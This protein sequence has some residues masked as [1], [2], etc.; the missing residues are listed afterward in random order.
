MRSRAEHGSGRRLIHECPRDTGGRVQLRRPQRRPVGDARWIRPRERRRRFENRQRRGSRHSVV[1]RR[2][3]VVCVDRIDARM[4][5]RRRRT[6][7]DDSDRREPLIVDAGDIDGDAVRQSVVGLGDVAE[8]AHDRRGLVDDQRSRRGDRFVI[9]AAAVA[10]L[11]RI[12]A[13]VHR[14]RCP[15][16]VQDGERS[17][18]GAADAVHGDHCRTRLARVEERRAR[19]L[20]GRH[21]LVHHD[22]RGHR[23]RRPVLGVGR[24]QRDRQRMR[25]RV[26]DRSRRRGVDDR[27]REIGRR[28][29][30]RAAE[31]RSVRDGGGLGPVQRRRAA[32]QR[33][34][35]LS[36]R[37]AEPVVA[38]ECR[39]NRVG[40]VADDL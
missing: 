38:V 7:V 21:R 15:A 3:I 14:Q 26:Q 36:S 16:V 19:D 11:K 8:R 22:R 40:I 24:S 31:C 33:D 39:G 17:Q 18:L 29:Q 25:S 35:C 1:V 37:C 32:E 20:H 12:G 5:R 9:R 2:S 28:V 13:S 23:S 10:H 4:D 34:V 27:A 30:L 6:V